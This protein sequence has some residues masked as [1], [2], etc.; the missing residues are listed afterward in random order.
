[1]T[2]AALPYHKHWSPTPRAKIKI[3]SDTANWIFYR[4]HYR[5]H[6]FHISIWERSRRNRSVKVAQKI[7][8]TSTCVKWLEWEASFLV[9]GVIPKVH[10]CPFVSH[11]VPLCFPKLLPKPVE[12]SLLVFWWGNVQFWQNYQ[13]CS[14]HAA[15]TN[16]CSS[17]LFFSQLNLSHCNRRFLL[18]GPWLVRSYSDRRKMIKTGAFPDG[19]ARIPAQNLRSVTPLPQVIFDCNDLIIKI[20]WLLHFVLSL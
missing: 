9:Q 12:S 3:E 19:S 5:W 20:R 11:N 4:W 15:A 17:F 16:L 14:I 6:L 10:H 8:F 13:H 7:F 1:M 18:K 2:D